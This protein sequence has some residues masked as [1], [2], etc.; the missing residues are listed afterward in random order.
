MALL[1]IY[2]GEVRY[3]PLFS[4]LDEE[5]LNTLL[6]SAKLIYK[7]T[8]ETLFLRDGRVDHFYILR[9]GMAKLYVSSS[10][11]NQKT[12]EIVKPGDAFCISEMFSENHR[13]S[14]SCQ[15]L[16]DSNIF[17]FSSRPYLNILRENPDISFSIMANLSRKMQSYVQQ[18]NSLSLHDARYRFANYLLSLLS[19]DPDNQDEFFLPIHKSEIASLLSIT[20]ETLS[21]ML[22][23]FD[24]EQVIRMQGDHIRILDI[25]RLKESAM[26]RKAPS[27]V[28]QVA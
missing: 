3:S 4:E 23:S 14:M 18:I 26:V 15:L 9:S 7:R 11:G 16:E 25:S 1:P 2:K 5:S 13:H 10:D 12:I 17:A 27:T 22:A 20:R 6:C 28:G 19:E 21:R 24:R 8:G